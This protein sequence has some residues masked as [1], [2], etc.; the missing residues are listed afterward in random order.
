MANT[1]KRGPGR[2]ELPPTERRR[3]VPW[4]MNDDERGRLA[5][6]A[7]LWGVSQSDAL[8]RA[9]DESLVRAEQHQ[10]EGR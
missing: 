8:R 9:I 3:P 10:G 2:P 1:S 6:L 7:E 4:R 5:R